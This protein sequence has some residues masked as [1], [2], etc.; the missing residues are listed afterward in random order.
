MKLDEHAFRQPRQY[1]QDGIYARNVYVLARVLRCLQ[2]DPCR[3]T[4]THLIFRCGACF[5]VK[6]YNKSASIGS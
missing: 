6:Q 3:S 1:L 5:R 4:G 2:R